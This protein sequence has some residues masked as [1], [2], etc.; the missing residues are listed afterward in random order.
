MI[1][2]KQNIIY[3]TL[4]EMVVIIAIIAM[5]ASIVTPIYFRQITK[6]RIN[7]AK[8]QI[9]LI[10]QAVM[11]YKLDTGNYPNSLQDLTKNVSSISN[12]DGPYLSK[13]VPKDPWGGEYVVV[14]PGKDGAFDIMCYGPD[15]KPGGTGRNADIIN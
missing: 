13:E 3:V 5:L 9:A 1:T 2:N 14:Y 4:I 12:W 6:A 8:T 10:E 7:T 11:D 15:L